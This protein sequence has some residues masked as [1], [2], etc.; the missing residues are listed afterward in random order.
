MANAVV[1]PWQFRELLNMHSLAK[2]LDKPSGEAAR[3]WARRHGL[4]MSKVGR[5]WRADK[6]DVDLAIEKDSR[7]LRKGA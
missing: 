5:E 6:R 7:Q 1:L 2:Y 4:P 3:K